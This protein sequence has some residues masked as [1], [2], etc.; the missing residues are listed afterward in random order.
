MPSASGPTIGSPDGISY[1]VT[2]VRQ[3]TRPSPACGFN[4]IGL[5]NPGTFQIESRH[6]RNYANGQL[7]SEW[8]EDV[9]TFLQC[10]SV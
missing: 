4:D 2:S 8:D 3:E 5:A 9:E 6:Y 7:L 1:T 10:E